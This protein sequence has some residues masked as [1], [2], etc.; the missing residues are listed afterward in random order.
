MMRNVVVLIT[1]A[2][3]LGG[4]PPPPDTH[5]PADKG[6]HDK[7]QHDKGQGD[8]ALADK[9][10]G[11]AKP[12][13]GSPPPPGPLQ[14]PPG[15]TQPL[16]P[17]PDGSPNK[18]DSDLFAV[19]VGADASQNLKPF[20]EDATGRQVEFIA[21]KEG[22]V[23]ISGKVA[24]GGDKRG[25]VVIDFLQHQEGAMLPTLKHTIS[26]DQPGTFTA[27]AP[28]NLGKVQIISYIDTDQNGPSTGE[29]MGYTDVKIE[30]KDI[31]GLDITIGDADSV[32]KPN[33]MPTK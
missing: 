6:Q 30:T 24:Y 19:G 17:P 29:P 32:D 33:D 1:F 31:T 14:A 18:I 23:T 15:Q 16:P 28:K 3:L 5:E 9:G 26:L 21:G 12:N 4:C 8:P 22:N 10:Q 11:E 20:P 7:G 25:K 2:L 27:S 13:V